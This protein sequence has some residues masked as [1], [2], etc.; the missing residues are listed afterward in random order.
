MKKG[1]FIGFLVYLVFGLYFLNLS[2]GFIIFPEFIT[3]LDK[4]IILVGAILI[5][6]GAINYFRVS[7][8]RKMNFH[9]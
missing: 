1:A 9:Y 5:I 8:V 3:Q 4:W 7:K 6:L 2:L